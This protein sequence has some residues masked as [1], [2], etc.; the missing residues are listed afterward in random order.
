VN[1]DV[2]DPFDLFLLRIRIIEGAVNSAKIRVIDMSASVLKACE[3]C[4]VDGE[5]VGLGV[6]GM[7]EGCFGAGLGEASGVLGAGE[8]C[9]A[10]WGGAVLGVIGAGEDCGG[11]GEGEGV[12]VGFEV[13]VETLHSHRA[14]RKARHFGK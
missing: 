4:G 7:G 10:V 11:V 12:G 5:D 14:I 3:G 6:S 8:D 2:F 9:G 1:Y 13:G